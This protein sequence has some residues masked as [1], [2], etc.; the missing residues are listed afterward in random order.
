LDPGP[1]PSGPGAAR[2]PTWNHRSPELSSTEVTIPLRSHDEAILVLGP[3]D[4]YA[5]LLR[6]DLDIEVFTRR[7]NLRLRGAEEG[8][9][10]ARRRIEHLLGKARKGR[11]LALAD[12]ESILLG[13]ES[14]AAA[15]ERAPAPRSAPAY[16]VL[17]PLSP[18]ERPNAGEAPEAAPARARPPHA[19]F[20][21]RGPPP[22]AGGARSPTVAARSENQRRYLEAMERNALVFGLGPAGTGKTFLA[23]SAALRALRLGHVRRIVI[24]RPVV[25]A[26]E[27][28]GFLPGDLQA[29]LNPYTRPIYD[30]FYDLVGFEEVQR[31]EEHGVIEVAPLA[32]M[33]GRTLAYAFAILDEGQNTT[34]PQ[35][36]MFLTRL[37]EGARMVV[38]GDPSQ[39][40]LEN[41]QRSGLNDAV[42]RLRGF[43]DVGV[44]EFG[45]QDIVRHPLVE[46]IVRAYEGPPRDKREGERREP[47]ARDGEGHGGRPGPHP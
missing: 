3:Y 11:E 25:E 42:A 35:M 33:R 22:S 8:V 1:P 30:A 34:V 10:E 7:G 16:R 26:G 31:L 9:Q 43:Q 20:A 47:E 40:D 46:Q 17:R 18:S 24:T 12:I 39:T 45:R 36:K 5:K 14:N 29:K 41:G 2:R 32:F 6:Q 28:L 13:T 19:A 44:V 15:S 37:G 23:V 38:T 4:R 27:R 21:E